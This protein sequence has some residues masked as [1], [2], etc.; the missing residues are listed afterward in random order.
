MFCPTV[1]FTLWHQSPLFQVSRSHA[2]ARAQ[3]H[4][5]QDSPEQGISLQQ[6]SLHTK[7]TT[8][9]TD[10]HPRPQRDSNPQSQQQSGCRP[11]P[12]T[13]GPPGSAAYVISRKIRKQLRFVMAPILRGIGGTK[14]N[15]Y[16]QTEFAQVLKTQ[17]LSTHSILKSTHGDK[18]H[19]Y[20]TK[21]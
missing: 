8:N 6:R 5:W 18:T 10:E 2:R 15:V 4:V 20:A 13:A 12:Q 19:Q 14:H 21:C 3:T 16:S 9:T 11:T 7:H 17:H 1:F